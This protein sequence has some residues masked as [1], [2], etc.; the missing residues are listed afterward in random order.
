MYALIDRNEHDPSPYSSQSFQNSR[1][2]LADNIDVIRIHSVVQGFFT[3]TLHADRNPEV[4]FLWLNRAVLV[5]C[6]SFDMASA[7]IARKTNTGLVE[8]YRLYEIH[9]IRLREHCTRHE[10]KT[11]MPQTLAMLDTRLARIKD[12]I[13]RRTPQSSSFI[14]G[15]GGNASQTSIF[16]R[17]SSS[18]DTN[19]ETPGDSDK[20]GISNSST[21]GLD[22]DQHEH[23]SPVDIPR[24]LS[25]NPMFMN[26]FPSHIDE[27]TG[28]ESDFENT[29]LPSPQTLRPSGSPSS[30]GGLW[31]EVPRRRKP[32]R[33]PHFELG[34]HRTTRAL[35]RNRY[36]DRKGSYRSLEPV[37]PRSMRAEVT[38]QV[39]QETVHGY[40]RASSPGP[41]SRGRLSG[42]SNAVV[43]LA[44]ISA[45]SP[46]PL[47]GRGVIHDRRS[48]SQRSMDR[49][50]LFSEAASYAAAVSGF[51]RDAVFGESGR[52]VTDQQISSSVH[53]TP[54]QPQ[55]A[56]V[57]SLQHPP[58][59]IGQLPGTPAS[60]TPMPPYPPTPGLDYQ[61]HS[62]G[63]TSSLFELPDHYNQENLPFVADPSSNLYPR[64]MGPVPM[65]KFDASASKRRHSSHGYSGDGFRINPGSL[66]SSLHAEQD[67]LSLSSP[68]IHLGENNSRQGG[69]TSQPISRDPSGP[70]IRSR[71]SANSLNAGEWNR[72]R[73][74]LAE[75]E[76]PPQLPDFSPQIPP[77]VDGAYERV[78]RSREERVTTWNGSRSEVARLSERLEEWTTITNL[79]ER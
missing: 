67:P 46:P 30:A 39:S 18:S 8:D 5:F 38:Q 35:E 47:R 22:P 70:Y 66:E 58:V 74:S 24:Q 51:A 54:N 78:Q 2:M 25:L 43:A 21:W 12:E 72:R 20:G 16:D 69:Y 62:P 1:E 60:Y 48:I 77:P 36:R 14:A 31:E 71:H 75:T 44:H 4:F 65:E 55:N 68:N 50:R 23:Q 29:V 57:Q 37:D 17:G 49:G 10:K 52:R 27:D 32:P 41:Q 15:G 59:S 34:D 28:Y 11:P 45:T 73:P 33:A 64:L 61:V 53:S 3:D 40:V 56:A 26:P 19:P 79:E 6:C 76:P 9:G 13:D 7:R 42:Q 63:S